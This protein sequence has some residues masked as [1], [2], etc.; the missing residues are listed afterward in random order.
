MNAKPFDPRVAAALAARYDDE[1]VRGNHDEDVR[2]DN[3]N[4]GGLIARALERAAGALGW[5][6]AERGALGGVV[7]RGARVLVKPNFVLHENQGP[8]GVE[9]LLT[10]GS[11]VRA[12]VSA[13][14]SA[15]A[16][17]VLVGDAPVQGC[18]F[19]ALLR[20]TKLNAWAHELA[21]R[22][23]R[24]RGVLDFRR[25]IST[26]DGGVRRATEGLQPEDRFALFDLGGESLLEPVTD[27]RESFRVTCYD[28]RMLARTHTKG[29][30]QYLVA[31]DVLEADVVINL[32]KL[33]T[34]MKAGVTCALKNLIGI[35]GNKEYLPHHRLG[36]SAR[37]G[38]CYPG[39]SR[40]KRALEFVFDKQNMTES[41]TAGRAW[42]TAAT[43]LYRVLHRTGGDRLGIEGSWSGND[44]IWRTCLD[45]NRILLYGRADG[46]MSD[47]PQRRVIHIV[48]AVVAGQGNGPLAPQPLALGLLLAGENAAAVDYAGA[49]LLGYEPERISVV[50]HALEDFRWPLAGFAAGEIS[51][52]GELGEGA[53]DTLLRAREVPPVVYPLGWRDAA[54]RAVAESAS[55]ADATHALTE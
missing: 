9:P 51:L 18:D 36:G 21:T 7:M 32:P 52:T 26:F 47:E 3:A 20:A 17:E 43:Q 29:R 4:G 6:D 10:H 5:L 12:V 22:E 55:S 30:H 24:F 54:V 28:P 41:P 37:G 49:L 33:K 40:I 39:E 16:S 38:D 27:E 8:W 11:L 53:A 48:D 2:G 31:K 13:A 19:P 1:D 15:G 50:R 34:H 45:L 42:A 14:L 35:N 25:T 46:T 23:P 44:T